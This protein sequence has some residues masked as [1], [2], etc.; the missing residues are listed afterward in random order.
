VIIGKKNDFLRREN[1]IK[2]TYMIKNKYKGLSTHT[3][4]D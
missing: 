3:N 1:T 2:T 4:G